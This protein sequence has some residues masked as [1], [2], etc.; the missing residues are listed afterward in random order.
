[1]VHVTTRALMRWYSTQSRP[2][3]KGLP[4]DGWLVREP[5]LHAR[6]SPGN[7]IM[8]EL[9]LRARG[10]GDDDQVVATNTSK[11]CGAVMRAA[12]FGLAFKPPQRTFESAME[13]GR[14][15]HG[16]PSGYLASGYLA[17]G[18]LATTVGVLARG[19][20]LR[21][22][23][24]VSDEALRQHAGHEELAAAI[25]RARAIAGRRIPSPA[26]LEALGGGWTGE[27][28]LAIALACLLRHDDRSPRAVE[29]PL[30]RAACHGGDS[31]STA[32]IA[33]NMLG[34]M[35]GA[36]ALPASWLRQLELRDVIE[37]IGRDLH[38]SIYENAFHDTVDYPPN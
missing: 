11:G 17:S 24:A 7:T 13:D 21:R 14:V 6:R 34:T 28:A 15:T 8:Q 22:A 19:G 25:A 20:T 9:A 2:T 23:M 36:K 26:D 18:Y 29:R 1:V 37:R 3:P 38:A 12:P 31:D 27:E 30:W 32:A 16:H 10:E 33:A 35:V 4:A 5:R